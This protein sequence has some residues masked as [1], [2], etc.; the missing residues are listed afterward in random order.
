MSAICKD[1]ELA[2]C[3]LALGGYEASFFFFLFAL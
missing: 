3:V 2:A 1:L